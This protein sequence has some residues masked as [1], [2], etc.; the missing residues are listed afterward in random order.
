MGLC[1][2]RVFTLGIDVSSFWLNTEDDFM[3]SRSLF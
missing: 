3:K 2:A 1:F